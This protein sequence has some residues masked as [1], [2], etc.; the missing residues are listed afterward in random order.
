MARRQQ[1][2]V[3]RSES[4]RRVAIVLS[5][6]PAAS[7]AKLLGSLSAESKAEVRS[8]MAN[9]ADVDPMERRLAMQSFSGMV[10]DQSPAATPVVSVATDRS[11]DSSPSPSTQAWLDAQDGP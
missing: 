10:R 7:A 3:Q 4:L 11:N 8:V 1:P 9:L 5:S 2:T 6:L